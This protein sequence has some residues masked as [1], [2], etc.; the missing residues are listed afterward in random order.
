MIELQQLYPIS[1]EEIKYLISTLQMDGS[2]EDI[3]YTDTKRSGWEP[4]IHTERIL[5]L[6]KYYYQ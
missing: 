2:W 1:S 5:K 3:N 6:T 4:K